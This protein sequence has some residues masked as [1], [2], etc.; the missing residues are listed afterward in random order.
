MHTSIRNSSPLLGDLVLN[1][2]SFA[3]SSVNSTNVT[4][5]GDVGQVTSV[6]EPR[7]GHGDVISGAFSLSLDEDRAFKEVS[8]VPWL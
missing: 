8:S 5:V 7:T 6:L 1:I 4:V 2:V 3:I